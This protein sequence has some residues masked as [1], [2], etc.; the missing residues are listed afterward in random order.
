MK[1][2]NV[3]FKAVSNQVL[4]RDQRL[5]TIRVPGTQFW[6]LYVFVA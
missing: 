1:I 5:A 6:Y 2:F 3:F 4:F